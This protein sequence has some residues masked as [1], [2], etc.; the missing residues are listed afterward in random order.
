MTHPLPIPPTATPDRSDTE[1][2]LYRVAICA[3]LYDPSSGGSAGTVDDDVAWCLAP[4]AHSMPTVIGTLRRTVREQ[5]INRTADHQAFIRQLS[6][7]HEIRPER[8]TNLDQ[9]R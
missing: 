8:A 4:V 5:I 6:A 1:A 9:E 7:L 2:V 3:F